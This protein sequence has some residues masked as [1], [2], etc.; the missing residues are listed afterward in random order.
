[1]A[2]D[3]APVLD[4]DSF[5]EIRPVTLDG[6]N[7]VSYGVPQL[8]RLADLASYMGGAVTIAAATPTVNGTVKQAASQPAAAGANPTKAEYD[9]LV[10]ALKTAGIM[11]SP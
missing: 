5:V 4:D 11:V 9:A 10:A 3:I 1:M 6:G 7:P 2:A 8:V